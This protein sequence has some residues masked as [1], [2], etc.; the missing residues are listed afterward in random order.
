MLL[1]SSPAMCE[2]YVAMLILDILHSLAL[3][4]FRLCR[5]TSFFTTD[6]RIQPGHGAVAG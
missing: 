5:D 3:G 6:D 4:F 2:V 1:A